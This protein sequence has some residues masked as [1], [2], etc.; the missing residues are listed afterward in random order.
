VGI[1]YAVVAWMIIQ[2]A[3]A[4]FS[5]FGIPD[6]AFRFVVLMVLTGIPCITYYRLGR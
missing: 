4:T 6:R 1:V 2:I 3:A 5:G